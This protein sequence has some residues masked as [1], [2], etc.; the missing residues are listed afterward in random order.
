[1]SNHGNKRYTSD[2][3]DKQWRIIEP[4]IPPEK[5]GG[6][7][8]E[9]AMREVINGILYRVKNGCSWKNLPKDFPAAKTVYHYFREWGLDGTWERVHACLRTLVRR[10]AGKSDMPTACVIDSQSVKTTSKGGLAVMTPARRS[11]AANGVTPSLRQVS[12]FVVD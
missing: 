10:K 4:L 5:F 6:R 7:P 3:T 1:M 12:G 8:R 11:K 2:L 9:V